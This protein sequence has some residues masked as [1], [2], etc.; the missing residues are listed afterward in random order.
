MLL[1]FEIDLV[2]QDYCM[3]KA[4]KGGFSESYQSSL[5][6]QSVFTL[7]PIAIKLQLKYNFYLHMLLIT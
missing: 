1:V 2:F 7:G 5:Q 4:V 6:V 3:L